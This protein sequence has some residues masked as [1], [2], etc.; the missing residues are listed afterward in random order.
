MVCYDHDGAELWTLAG[1]W[2]KIETV[3]ASDVCGL[4][5]SSGLLFCF[6][7]AG[8]ASVLPDLP[9]MS[10]IDFSGTDEGEPAG[11]GIDA[12]NQIV[13]FGDD[14]FFGSTDEALSVLA[15]NGVFAFEL[16]AGAFSTV[17]S[18]VICP[19]VDAIGDKGPEP[20][21]QLLVTTVGTC[22]Y[23]GLDEDGFGWCLPTIDYR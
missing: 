5:Q 19:D 23:C 13:T 20:E 12:A 10:L 6:D 17:W 11:V 4:D 16:F 18:P 22:L 8:A 1:P 15:G 2:S 3:G 21:G 14:F 9:N 7:A